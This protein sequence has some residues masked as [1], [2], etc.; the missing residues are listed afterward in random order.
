MAFD[1][2]A[3]PILHGGK[4]KSH[5]PANPSATA[6]AVTGEQFVTVGTDEQ[7]LLHL[8]GPATTGIDL[9]GRRLVPGLTDTHTHPIRGGLSF[10]MELC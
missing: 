2:H 4:L 10:N 9:G 8:R 7:R 5:D 3:H 6:L 1:E